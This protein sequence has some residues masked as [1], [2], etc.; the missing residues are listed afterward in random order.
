MLAQFPLKTWAKYF[1]LAVG[2]RSG[3]SSQKW[4]KTYLTYDITHIKPEIQNK[5]FFSLLTE[6]LAESFEG[7]NSSLVQSAGSYAVGKSTG[8]SLISKYDIF[9]DW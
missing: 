1:R 9:V 8:F 4:P 3:T 5:R 2:P 6:R 7:L